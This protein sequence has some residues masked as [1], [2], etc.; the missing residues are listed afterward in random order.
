MMEKKQ[1]EERE[2]RALHRQEPRMESGVRVG[3]GRHRARHRQRAA[4][5]QADRFRQLRGSS[6]AGTAF[7][8][9]RYTEE[10]A[11]P[12]ADRLDGY[13]DS[14]LESLKFCS[15]SAAPTYPADGH[16][17]SPTA[18]SSR[19]TSSAPDDPFIKAALKGKSPADAARNALTNTK[20]GD[21]ALREIARRWRQGRGRRFNRSA[22]RPRSH[23]RADRAEHAAKRTRTRSRPSSPRPARSSAARDSRSYG[24]SAYPDATFTLRLTFGTVKGYPMNGTVAPPMTTLYG[25][26]D[27]A[28]SFGNKP[29]FDLPKRF[30]ERRARLTSRRRSTSSPTATSSAATRARR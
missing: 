7:A 12:D 6:L 17:R 19:S 21:A 8:I 1:Q 28:Q 4:A 23:R 29:P 30:V 20:V 11:K 26:F 10:V 2:F 5:L 24:Q 9:V 16:R 22:R 3:V 25:L 14:Q 18:C 27:R 15:C 13:H